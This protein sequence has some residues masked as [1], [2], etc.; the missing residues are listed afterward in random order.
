MLNAD[1]E[2]DG[3][4]PLTEFVPMADDV[5]D[6]LGAIHPVGELV[7]DVVAEPGVARL[8]DQD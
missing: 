7:L 5:A 8:S 4:A 2:R 1:G 3:A 6:Q